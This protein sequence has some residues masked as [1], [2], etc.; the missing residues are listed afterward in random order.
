M[1]P[2]P[3]DHRG[4][5][6]HEAKAIQEVQERLQARFPHLD[7]RRIDAAVTEA[8]ASMTGPIRDFVPV[9]VERAAIEQLSEDSV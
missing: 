3:V 5:D 7:A 2:L 9:L 4:M 8:H 1:R 6:A